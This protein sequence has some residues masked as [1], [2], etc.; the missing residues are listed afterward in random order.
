MPLLAVK[1]LLMP[2]YVLFITAAIVTIVYYAI[3]IHQDP[4]L[5]SEL[6]RAL[7]GFKIRK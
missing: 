7:Q 3:V 4:L 5:K 6:L 2:I 1:L